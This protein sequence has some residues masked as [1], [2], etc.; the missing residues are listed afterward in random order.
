MSAGKA[1]DSETACLSAQRLRETWGI[2]GRA[3]RPREKEIRP[4]GASSPC[5]HG[6]RQGVVGAKCS[7]ACSVVFVL[8]ARS[9]MW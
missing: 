3:A 9:E 6:P 2:A 7:A 1:I 4:L 5:W 8:A